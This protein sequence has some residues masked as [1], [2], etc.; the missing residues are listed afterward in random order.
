MCVNMHNTLCGTDL[1]NAALGNSTEGPGTHKPWPDF[2]L[3]WWFPGPVRVISSLGDL[4]LPRSGIIGEW[5]KAG[6]GQAQDASSDPFL[7]E[8][9]SSAFLAPGTSFVEDNFS[10]DE[11]GECFRDD[12]S[13]LYLLC[14]LFL[15]LLHYD[16]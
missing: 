6:A 3:L 11:G 7:L 14:T 5:G 4:L 2:R 1:R 15:L 13:T 16:I 12:S 9:R 8:Q 10:M